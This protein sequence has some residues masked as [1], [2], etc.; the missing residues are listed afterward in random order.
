MVLALVLFLPDPGHAD[1]AQSVRRL[2]GVLSAPKGDDPQMILPTTLTAP[3]PSK[4]IRQQRE[5]MTSLEEELA[6]RTQE[7]T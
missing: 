3:H 6:S 5:D 4:H 7:A 2:S 1:P